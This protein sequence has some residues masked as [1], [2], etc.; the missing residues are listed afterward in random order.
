MTRC[1]AAT[2][3]DRQ[4]NKADR[5]HADCGASRHT[6]PVDVLNNGEVGNYRTEKNAPQ[7]KKKQVFQVKKCRPD[8][9]F[10]GNSFALCAIPA[11]YGIVTFIT[12]SCKIGSD[13]TWAQKNVNNFE[14]IFSGGHKNFA[15]KAAAACF[16]SKLRTQ[17]RRM[18]P[19]RRGDFS[20]FLPRG[21]ELGAQNL[22]AGDWHFR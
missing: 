10:F 7:Q 12:S 11:C 19:R 21:R 3:A 4:R 16:L 20:D 8:R 22:A 6:L 15:P 5:A 1:R 14:T 9:S 17:K 2:A 13:I 18:S